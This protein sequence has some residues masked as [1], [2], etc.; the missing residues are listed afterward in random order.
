[1]ANGSSEGA[2]FSHFLFLSSNLSVIV[3]TNFSPTSQHQLYPH[4]SH[5]D[6]I[7]SSRH[8][9]PTS[10]ALARVP[11]HQA[12]DELSFALAITQLQDTMTTPE[13]LDK[14]RTS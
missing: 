4:I 5:C 11:S 13:N 1:M 10:S 8:S 14:G 3:T 7:S 6:T 2:I 12:G 9:A